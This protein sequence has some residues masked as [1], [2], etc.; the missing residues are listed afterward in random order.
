MTIQFVLPPLWAILPNQAGKILEMYQRQL[1]FYAKPPEVTAKGDVNAILDLDESDLKNIPF[2]FR[3]ENGVGV[4]PIEGVIIPKSDFFSRFFGGFAALDVLARDFTELIKREDVHTIVLDVDSPGGNAFGVEQFA[5]LIF[6]SR[7]I[8]PIIAVTSGMMASGAA[9][10]GTAAHKVFITGEVTVTGS[11]GTVTT[12]IDISELDKKI[13]VKRTEVAAGEFKRVPSMFEPLTEKGRAVLQGQV[14]H[15]TEA[16]INNIAM[17]KGVSVSTVSRKMAD[18]K[19][20][21]GTQGVKAGLIDNLIS[22]DNIFQSVGSS[23]G[24]KNFI[25]KLDNNFNSFIGGPSM[26]IQERI[27]EM[28]KTDVDFYNA[29]VETGRTEANA[30]YEA[31]LPDVLAAEHAKGFEAGKAEGI[32]AGAEGEQKRISGL[33]ELENAENKEL[34]EKFIADGKTTAPEA[35]VEILKAQKVSNKAALDKIEGDS[36]DAVDTDGDNNLETDDS[37]KGM[38]QLVAEYMTE[39]KCTKGHAITIIAKSHPDAKNDFI[40]P[41]KK[42]Q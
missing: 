39:H 26:T 24:A 37:K 19:V 42:E 6:E 15:V 8:K 23:E 40:T 32:T 7:N 27:L 38:K 20:F 30:E 25:G 13:G 18:G 16:F 41:V 21:I 17:F 11:I 22:M 12:H 14:D 4:L 33:R 35:A 36:P 9:W 34:V 5:N 28:M 10:I 1:E 31:N 29:I 2:G 3:V